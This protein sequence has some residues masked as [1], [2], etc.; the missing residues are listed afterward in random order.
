MKP[1][2]KVF[3]AEHCPGCEEAIHIAD[4]IKQDYPQAFNVEVVDITKS[5]ADIPERVFATPTYML[6]DRIVSLG[7]PKPED[8]AEWVHKVATSPSS[9]PKTQAA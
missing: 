7:N 9:N 6:N 3:I 4:N 8:I 2:L 5:Q 1:N